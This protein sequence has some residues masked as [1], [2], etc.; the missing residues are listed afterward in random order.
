MSDQHKLLAIDGGGIRGVLALEVLAE[1]E[2]QL[3]DAHKIPVEEYRLSD[4]FDYVSGTSTGAVVAAC[5]SCGMRVREIM[6]FYEETGTKMFDNRFH[7]KLW[8]WIRYQSKYDSTPLA[9]ALQDMFGNIRTLEPGNLKCLFMAVTKNQTT[10]SAWPISSNPHAKYNDLSLP[11]CNLKITL[12]QIV[13]ASTAA[14][15]AYKGERIEWDENDPSKHFLFVDG[16][17]TPYNNPAWLLYRMATESGYNLSWPT[18]EDKL[19]LVSVGTGTSAKGDDNVLRKATG[20][21]RIW[22]T[23]KIPGALIQGIMVDQD[24]NCRQ[25]GR[26]VYGAKLDSEVGD[27]IP[28]DGSGNKIPLSTDLGRKFLYARYN[29]HLEQDSLDAMGLTDVNAEHVQDLGSTKHTGELRQVGQRVAQ[30]LD[31]QDFAPFLPDLS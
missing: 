7:R 15:T 14:P 8:S 9:K 2:Q 30:D 4:F 13:R 27:M 26:C 22:R 12:W 20:L 18:G 29:A 16:G 6:D 28:R 10:D 25:V 3:A 1:L 24:T 5:V 23:R 21:G 11:D 17:V 31:I 19:L